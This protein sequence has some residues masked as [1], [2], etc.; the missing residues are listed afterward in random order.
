VST[1][2]L[3]GEGD[4]GPGGDCGVE[5]AAGHERERDA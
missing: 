1:Q 5:K 3:D 4:V 2:D